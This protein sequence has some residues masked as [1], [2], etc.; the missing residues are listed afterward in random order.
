MGVVWLQVL[1]L[2]P[3]K[4]WEAKTGLK[5]KAPTIAQVKPGKKEKTRPPKE[6]EQGGG[7]SPPIQKCHLL[8]APLLLLLRGAGLLLLPRLNLG[9]R[10]D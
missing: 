3:K 9:L 8:H 10:Q 4:V 7:P 2:L 5:E 6:K 1:V